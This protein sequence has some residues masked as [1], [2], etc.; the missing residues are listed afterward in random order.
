MFEGWKVWELIV[1]GMVIGFVI[2]TV[3]GV[4]MAKIFAKQDIPWYIPS[5]KEQH[6]LGCTQGCLEQGLKFGTTEFFDCVQ[7][8]LHSPHKE[9]SK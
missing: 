7:T 6:F 3:L 8:C 9:P 1:L 4:I 5:A 2:A